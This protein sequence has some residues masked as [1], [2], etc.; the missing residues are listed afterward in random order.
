M[1]FL[2]TLSPKT[3]LLAAGEGCSDTPSLRLGLRGLFGRRK[4]LSWTLAALPWVT[5]LPQVAAAPLYRADSQG[6][7]VISS[8]RPAARGVPRG[9]N[10]GAL[11]TGFLLSPTVW[12]A[13]AS[14]R[15]RG[16]R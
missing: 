15:C 12:P 2:P 14:A 13:L 7:W 9:R 16:R 8:H 1:E 4:H 6:L 11:G 10:L 5:G 3:A